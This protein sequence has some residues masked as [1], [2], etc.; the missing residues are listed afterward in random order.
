MTPRLMLALCAALLLAACDTTG[1]AKTADQPAP[2]IANAPTGTVVPGEMDGIDANIGNTVYFD[3]DSSSLN[4]EA[5][6]QLKKEA[7]WLQQYKQHSV[8]IEGHADERGTRE[9]NLALG[10]RRAEAIVSYLQAL[11][12]DSGRL[13]E[14]SY[15]KERPIC[16]DSTETCW[17]QNRR[18]VTTLDN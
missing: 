8:T 17:S 12:I 4:T 2:Q 10:E 3:T 5:Q 6:A 11:G 18:G 15:G 13:K 1:A 14:I 16:V 7:L 9:Y